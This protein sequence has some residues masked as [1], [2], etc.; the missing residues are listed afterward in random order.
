MIKDIRM[1]LKDNYTITDLVRIMA[2][3]RAEDGCPWDRVQTHQSIRGN[4][5]E[6]AYEAVDAIDE[7]DPAAL[8]EELG[9][10][11][12]QVV[13]HSTMAEEADDFDFDEVADGICKKL[14]HR[15]PHIF[16]EVIADTPEQVLSNWDQIKQEEKHQLTATDTLQSVPKAFPALM[17]AA[18]VQKRAAKAGFDW[19]SVNGA[20][21]KMQEEADELRAAISSENQQ[22]IEEELGDL[23]FSAVNVSRFIKADAEDALQKATNKFILRFKKVELL[24][25]NRGIDMNESSM[26]VLDG[27]WDEIKHQESLC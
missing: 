13:F 10:V 14:I 23:L 27:L 2:L 7:N 19:T 4:L 20:L 25:E 22:D 5:L 24:A 9:D 1:E 21:E 3:L 6:E 16:A 18:K 26:D 8:C 17:R 11:L 15:H 12:L